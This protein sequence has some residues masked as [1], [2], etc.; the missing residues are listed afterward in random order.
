MPI[1]R[2]RDLAGERIG[3]DGSGRR[4]DHHAQRNVAP[5]FHAARSEFARRLGEQDAG[6]AHLVDR[7]DQRQHDAQV[8]VHRRA[9]Q[10]P[11]LRA[12]DLRL[13]EAH[14]DGAPAEERIRFRGEPAYGQLVAADVERANH[15]RHAGE[16][17]DHAPVAA[18]LLFLVGHRGATHDEEFGAHEPHA[19][20]P[21]VARRVRVLGQI[22]VGAQQ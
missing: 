12:E 19:L 6:L 18:V 3:G 4:L 13:I 8:A 1:L 14:A 2:E 17:L 11:Q 10:R 15:H 21:A 7:D 16:R 9:Q 5:E 22:D 20:G